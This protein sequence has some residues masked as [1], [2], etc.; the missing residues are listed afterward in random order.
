MAFDVSIEQVNHVTRIT[1]VFKVVTVSSTDLAS[2]ELEQVLASVHSIIAR[3]QP[4][5]T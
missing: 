5:A 3:A 4:A 1:N 2:A